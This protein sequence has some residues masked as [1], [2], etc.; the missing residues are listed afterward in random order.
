MIDRR[1]AVSDL[2]RDRGDKLLVVAGLGAPA[3]DCTAAGDHDLTF[4][5]WGAMGGA[6]PMGLGLAQAQPDKPVMVIT[7]D[8]EMLMGLG[9][10]ATIAPSI[11]CKTVRSSETSCAPCVINSSAS[12]DFPDPDGPRIKTP[13]PSNTTAVPCTR[14]SP[15]SGC[16]SVFIENLT[17]GGLSC[18]A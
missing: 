17:G 16:V 11:R 12:D 9:A 3:W 14:V 2:L 15:R 1:Q 13:L 10:L 6:V 5:L 4:P 18:P 7:G 8:G